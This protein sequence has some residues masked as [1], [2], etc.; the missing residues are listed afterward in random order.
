MITAA[1]YDTKAYDSEHSPYAVAEHAVALLLTLNRKTL[2][3]P[4]SQARC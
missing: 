1:V 3:S 4:S 2:E